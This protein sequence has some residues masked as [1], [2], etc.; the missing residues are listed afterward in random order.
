M[1]VKALE[2]YESEVSYDLIRI[3]VR[4]TN[5]TPMV[6]TNFGEGLDTGNVGELY[7]LLDVVKESLK[8]QYLEKTKLRSQGYPG[9]E[10]P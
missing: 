10:A 2:I 3:G 6:I 8:R 4:K 1:S 5:L 7:L 9:K